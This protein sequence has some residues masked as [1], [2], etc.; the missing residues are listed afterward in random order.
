MLLTLL[1]RWVLLT[2]L[3]CV[4]T[5]GYCMKLLGSWVLGAADAAGL[6]D[7]A[8]AAGLLGIGCC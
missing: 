3:G 6:W 5:L 7:A 8:G 4:A 2:L 1:G